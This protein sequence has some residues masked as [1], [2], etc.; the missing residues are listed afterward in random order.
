M[1]TAPVSAIGRS[2]GIPCG[3]KSLGQDILLSIS[4]LLLVGAFM[5]VAPEAYRRMIEQR[6][7]NHHCS[8]I[9]LLYSIGCHLVDFKGW[10]LKPGCLDILL[11]GIIKSNLSWIPPNPHQ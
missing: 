4:L 6:E 9:L 1:T 10:L 7:C 3:R 2:R 5:A 8:P 11:G